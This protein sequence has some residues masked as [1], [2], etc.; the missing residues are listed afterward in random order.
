MVPLDAPTKFGAIP[1]DIFTLNEIAAVVACS[2]PEPKSTIL[3]IFTTEH[4]VTRIKDSP[5]QLKGNDVMRKEIL[6]SGN[7]IC[8]LSAQILQREF[9]LLL[10]FGLF[11]SSVAFSRSLQRCIHG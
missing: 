3:S 10:C 7:G 8:K 2:I 9:Q 4:Y 5:N 6:L 1:V 11:S